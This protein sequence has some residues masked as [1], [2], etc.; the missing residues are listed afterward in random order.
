[1]AK[2]GTAYNTAILLR[3]WLFCYIV[4]ALWYVTAHA[5]HTCL[6]KKDMATGHGL[7]AW[8]FT[9]YEARPDATASRNK[10]HIGKG[11]SIH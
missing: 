7:Q 4:Y 9:Y 3:I 10:R 11:T 2:Y 8:R 6:I 5:D 1:M